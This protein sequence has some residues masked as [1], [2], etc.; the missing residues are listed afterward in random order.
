MTTE[1]PNKIDL[2]NYKA[3][4]GKAKLP[5]LL[6]DIKT[7]MDNFLTKEEQDFYIKEVS[8]MITGTRY[9]TE[10]I[11]KDIQDGLADIDDLGN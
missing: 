3:E 9:P 7:N 5:K 4:E 6:D 11:L 2:S 1:N 10:A 8:F